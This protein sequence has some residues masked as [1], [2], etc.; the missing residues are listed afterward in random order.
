[1]EEKMNL[2][3][4][5]MHFSGRIRGN[6]TTEIGDFIQEMPVE[7]VGESDFELDVG[8]NGDRGLLMGLRPVEG[9]AVYTVTTGQNVKDAEYAVFVMPNGSMEVIR[10]NDYMYIYGNAGSR[11]LES[12]S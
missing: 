3:E 9:N 4:K 7:I 8:N 10:N 5:T 6:C 1:V 12:E 2:N 11:G